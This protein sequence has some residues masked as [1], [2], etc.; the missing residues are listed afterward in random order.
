MKTRLVRLLLGVA[1]LGGVFGAHGQSYFPND[2]AGGLT[3][4]YLSVMET[5][6]AMVTFVESIADVNTYC[7]PVAVAHGGPLQNQKVI[8]INLRARTDYYTEDAGGNWIPVVGS[9]N[10][11][12]SAA[13][14][15][16]TFMFQQ[17]L[18]AQ[19]RNKKISGFTLVPHSGW[20][21]L[22]AVRVL[23]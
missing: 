22:W 13:S 19:T 16:G 12:F 11:K 15:T 1:F 17:L 6:W 14:S 10:A 8:W 18:V 23:P 7:T 20:C 9:N 3:V 4:Q 5:G 2:P 21:Q